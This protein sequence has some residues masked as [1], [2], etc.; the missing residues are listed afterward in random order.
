MEVT[1]VR[2]LL[3]TLTACISLLSPSTLQAAGWPMQGHD[4]RNSNFSPGEQVI[5]RQNVDRL[6][7]GWTVKGAMQVVAVGGNLFASFGAHGGVAVLN[8]RTGSRLQ[9]FTDRDL[10]FAS[11]DNVT[12]LAYAR[13]LL[14]VASALQIV[15]LDTTHRRIVW[16]DRGGASSLVVAAGIVYTGQ[17]CQ[18]FCGAPASKALELRSGRLLWRHPGNFGSRPTL[19]AGELYQAWGEV[20]GATHVYDPATGRL[21]RSLSLFGAWTGDGRSAYVEGG[22][23]PGT[24]PWLTSVRADGTPAWRL[25]LGGPLS[26][27]N[28]TLAYG[29]LYVASNRYHPGI[30][31]VGTAD[32]HLAW[33]TDTSPV[34]GLIVANHLVFA[35]EAEAARLDVLDANTGQLLRRIPIP[36]LATLLITQGRLYAASAQGVTKMG[37]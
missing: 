12:D 13:G 5:N 29:R 14:V 20:S 18:S 37:L 16:R 2:Y 21:V 33:G 7:A 9:S 17:G 8:G 34:T 15:A 26:Y 23:T 3:W 28:P 32:G 19:I 11:A 10:G 35:A 24:R 22:P 1:P 36:P 31:A 6:H 30:I 25:P 4:P 27:S